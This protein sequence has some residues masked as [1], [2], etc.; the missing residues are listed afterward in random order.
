MS[1][2][3]QLRL[4]NLA[5][6][7]NS[8]ESQIA[9]LT[10]LVSVIEARI[11]DLTASIETQT[12]ML[13]ANEGYT[14]LSAERPADDPLFAELQAQYAALFD[15]GAL[16]SL[17]VVSGSELSAAILAR[18]D[19]L[20]A[21]GP[22]AQASTVLTSTTPLLQ[23][24]QQQYPHLFDVGDLSALTEQV[25]ADT[26]LAM[27]GGERSRELLQ[28]QGLED[29][30][31]YTAAA[32]PLT[33]AIDTVERE[34]KALQAQREAEISRRDQ[35]TRTR[36]LTLKSLTTLNNKIAELQLASSALTSEVRFAS[37]AL[38]PLRPE[39]RTSLTMATAL[40]ALVGLFLGVFVAFFANY[41]GKQPFLRKRAQA[42]A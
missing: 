9:E 14:L 4:D 19:E 40:G 15:V 7:N 29:L 17:D 23:T 1:I 41:M 33:A 31:T 27:L 26:G 37:P 42:I 16:A 39:E 2:P 21:L 3:L 13:L 11:A 8:A 20:F 18:Y 36:D 6:L 32:A 28:L 10:A 12:Q 34:I 5:S 24:I 35:L 30:P 38:P 22:L 25:M